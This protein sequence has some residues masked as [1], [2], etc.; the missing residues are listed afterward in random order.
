MNCKNCQ[1]DLPQEAK[2]CLQCGQ[3]VTSVNRPFGSVIR[4]MTHEVLDIDG[5]LWLTLRTLLTKPGVMTLEYTQGKRAK[6]TPP[7]RMY[8][9]ISIL[10]FVIFSEVYHFY[11]PNNK[12]TDSTINYYSK[13]MFVLF[14]VFAVIVQLF[15]QKSYYINNLVF[16]MHLHCIAY[17][18]LMYVAP[19]EI[20]EQ[21]HWF[22]LLLQLPAIAYLIWYILT[23]F[24]TV[25]QQG[26]WVT[27][28]K[29]F[30]I[31]M[32]YMAMLG[33]MFDIVIERIF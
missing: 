33:V 6:Y 30:S 20:I 19:L 14:P 1:I 12:L 23:A 32:I 9:A 29:V 21:K 16:S 24:L 13:A 10:F 11:D 3:R 7:L 22:F 17:L 18:M 27:L 2:Y 4:D 8:L 31:Y 28:G 15:F 5:R 25:Y 26:R